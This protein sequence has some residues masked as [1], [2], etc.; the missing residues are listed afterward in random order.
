MAQAYQQ[1]QAEILSALAQMGVTLNPNGGISLSDEL[2]DTLRPV[3]APAPDP[4]TAPTTTFSGDLSAFRDPP[5]AAAPPPPAPEVD[6][7]Q[8][9]T[10]REVV[11]LVQRLQVGQTPPPY[12]PAQPPPLPPFRSEAVLNVLEA[13]IRDAWKRRGRS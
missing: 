7:D 4:Y 3:P 5:P 9:M 10:R 2:L 13:Q 11:A 6:F 1:A 8:P 12:N